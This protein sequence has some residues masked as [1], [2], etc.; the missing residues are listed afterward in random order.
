MLNFFVYAKP[1]SSPYAANALRI[2]TCAPSLP[3]RSHNQ[4]F[5]ALSELFILHALISIRINTYKSPSN[6]FI[7]LIFN[8]TRI[9]TSGAKDLKSRRINTS[10][11]KD[12]KSFRINTSKKRVG[13]LFLRILSSRK[14][15]GSA[16]PSRLS[17]FSLSLL[18]RAYA[19][20]APT[21]LLFF[22]RATLVGLFR[23]NSRP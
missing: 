6:P 12:L 15:G 11:N 9:N 4:H 18:S 2:N 20:L 21:V 17:G 7:L 14:F 1:N 23:R 8:P 5:Q 22:V 3:Q 10:G 13:G 19:P 16:R